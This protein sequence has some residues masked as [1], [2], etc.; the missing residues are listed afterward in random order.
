MRAV[1]TGARQFPAAINKAIA[2]ALRKAGDP[3]VTEVGMEVDHGYNDPASR[4]KPRSLPGCKPSAWHQAN[5]RFNTENQ[6]SPLFLLSKGENVHSR[7]MVGDKG[8]EPL[9]SPV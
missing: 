2:E 8:L 5:S 3:Q 4:Y 1:A 9:T 6:R 7:G